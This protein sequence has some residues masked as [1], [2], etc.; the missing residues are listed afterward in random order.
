M[1]GDKVDYQYIV[2]D[3]KQ[4]RSRFAAFDPSKMDSEMIS[5]SIKRVNP[6]P[7]QKRVL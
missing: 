6:L 7:W 3:P 5:D 1:S 4:I 2:I